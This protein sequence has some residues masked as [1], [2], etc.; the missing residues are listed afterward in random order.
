MIN[1]KE[2]DEFW[3]FFRVYLG[4]RLRTC[5]L[6]LCFASFVFLGSVELTSLFSYFLRH[7]HKVNS[8]LQQGKASFCC[9]TCKL[10][11]V[12]VSTFTL[13]SPTPIPSSENSITE[14]AVCTWPVA[15]AITYMPSR[16][17]PDD[18]NIH[19]LAVGCERASGFSL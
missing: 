5:E 2:S 19:T 4:I 7:A 12:K 17:S 18:C 9:T 8:F 10:R 14:W 6:F 11:I 1:Y 16:V 15:N 13:C 3:R